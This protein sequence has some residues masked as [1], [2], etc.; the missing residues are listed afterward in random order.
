MGR[1]V[2]QDHQDSTLFVDLIEWESL[3]ASESAEKA[4]RTAAEL[5]ACSAAL[6]KIVSFHTLHSYS[7][8]P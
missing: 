5:K 4:M 7:S 2:K 1:T 6:D 3:E 8:T